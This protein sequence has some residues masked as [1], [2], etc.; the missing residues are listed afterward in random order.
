MSFL[1][2]GVIKF[3]KNT[4]FK[5]H[6]TGFLVILQKPVWASIRFLI[7]FKIEWIKK[8]LKEIDLEMIK[9]LSHNLTEWSTGAAEIC[10]ENCDLILRNMVPVSFSFQSV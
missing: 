10:Y 1:H 2:P 3:T 9:F 7:Q 8:C 5:A 4:T 6:L